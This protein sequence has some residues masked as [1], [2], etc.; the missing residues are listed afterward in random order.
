MCCVHWVLKRIWLTAVSG[1]FTLTCSTW[2]IEKKQLKSLPIYFV[3]F[4]IGRFTSED[5][6]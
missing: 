5:E 6:V 1:W 4:G 2:F 3:R